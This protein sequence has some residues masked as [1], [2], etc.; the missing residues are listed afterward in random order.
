M[1]LTALQNQALRSL[2]HSPAGLERRHL[3]SDGR[4]RTASERI[5]AAELQVRGAAPDALSMMVSSIARMVQA[6]KS[7]DSRWKSS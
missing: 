1:D 4:T 7:S 2:D 6:G 5:L 3:E